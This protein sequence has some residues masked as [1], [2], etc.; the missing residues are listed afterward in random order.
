MNHS[1]IK[2]IYKEFNIIKVGR[3]LSCSD[4][5]IV[6][7]TIGRGGSREISKVATMDFRRANFSFFRDLLER[8]TWEQAVQ[9]RGVQETWLIFQHH[10][11]QTQEQCIL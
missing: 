5:E 7:F 2:Y 11:F 9:T 3:S 4:H 10:F 1:I 6:D 8:I